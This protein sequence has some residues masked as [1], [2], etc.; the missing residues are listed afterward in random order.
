MGISAKAFEGDLSKAVGAVN[1][2][3][4]IPCAV[5]PLLVA[6]VIADM[7]YNVFMSIVE[8]DP[9]GKEQYHATMGHSVAH[10]VTARAKLATRTITS[11]MTKG[12]SFLKNAFKTTGKLLTR[13][14]PVYD[15]ATWYLFLGGVYG[16]GLY[17][18]SAM[19]KNMSPCN[20]A[21]WGDM[22]A[23]LQY[24]QFTSW[25][26]TSPLVYLQ[27][28]DG[29]FESAMSITVEPGGMGWVVLQCSIHKYFSNEPCNFAMRIVDETTGQVMDYDE[30]EQIKQDDGST[31]FGGATVFAQFENSTGVAH[32]I[33]LE[34]KILDTP[35]EQIGM[36][37]WATGYARAMGADEWRHQKEWDKDVTPER[38]KAA[39]NAADWCLR[40]YPHLNPSARRSFA[41][42]GADTGWSGK[43]K[44]VAENQQALATAEDTANL[45]VAEST[46][47]STAPASLTVKAEV[48]GALCT[49]TAGTLASGYSIT[50]AV[51]MAFEKGVV[52]DG[53]VAVDVPTSYA[54]KSPYSAVLAI[55]PG[56]WNVYGYFEYKDASGVAQ[57]SAALTRAV[58]VVT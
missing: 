15:M 4:M 17:K 41:V 38:K 22:L 49:L 37:I 19:L 53:A 20:G 21:R 39:R 50:K 18:A 12:S 45:I 23:G 33:S 54:T 40:T 30:A 57:T 27:E 56:T 47:S 46:G 25:Q 58:T 48:G 32:T 2:I 44:F 9:T 1:R 43:L 34:G 26:W 10:G 42:A 14:V 36:F 11:R 31:K 5:N 28:A 16:S 3:S 51:F 52:A 24:Q 55:K 6:A 7:N 13:L 29:V 8:P 35:E